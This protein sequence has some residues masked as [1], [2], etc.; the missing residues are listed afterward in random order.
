MWISFELYRT[1]H[2]LSNPLFNWQNGLDKSGVVGTILM[3]V[4]KAFGC[5]SHDLIIPKLHA[6]GL[7]HDCLRLIRSYLSNRHQKTKLDSVFSS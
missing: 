2:A 1:Q 5:L 4:S 7:D 6:Y 3:D